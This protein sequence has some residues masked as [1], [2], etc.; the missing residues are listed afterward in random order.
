MTST[1][2]D[3][4]SSTEPIVKRPVIDRSEQIAA[5]INRSPEHRAAVEG[6]IAAM[7]AADCSALASRGSRYS[8]D[9]LLDRPVVV[10]R[11]VDCSDSHWGPCQVGNYRM[12]GSKQG[13]PFPNARE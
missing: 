9:H 3:T 2:D 8:N 1:I 12:D 11:E 4:G 6:H 7:D 5:R 13:G 10:H